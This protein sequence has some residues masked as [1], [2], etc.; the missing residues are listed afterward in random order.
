[1]SLQMQSAYCT[2][3]WDW[4]LNFIR[5]CLLSLWVLKSAYKGPAKALTETLCTDRVL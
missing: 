4:F 1:M 3:Q 5:F 2:Q